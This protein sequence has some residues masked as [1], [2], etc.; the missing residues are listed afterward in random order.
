MLSAR[1][2]RTTGITPALINNVGADQTEVLL[3]LG[4]ACARSATGM[5]ARA[6]RCPCDML[7]LTMAFNPQDKR[8]AWLCR[9]VT[10]KPCDFHLGPPYRPVINDYVT[11][12]RYVFSPQAFNCSN[13]VIH[14]PVHLTELINGRVGGGGI[15]N[16][17][18]HMLISPYQLLV[19]QQRPAGSAP[20]PASPYRQ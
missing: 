2:F 5:G 15:F 14:L 18:T 1:H 17:R 11:A 8:L 7:D 4:P 13:D 10:Q 16:S 19:G 6:I 3:M 20:C 12:W 9:G